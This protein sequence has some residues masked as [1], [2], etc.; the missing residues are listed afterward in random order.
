MT[1][2]AHDYR[3]ALVRYCRALR[4]PGELRVIELVWHWHEMASAKRRLEALAEEMAE[5]ED[6]QMGERVTERPGA[7]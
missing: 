6:E 4:R 2:P 3:D 1:D 7:I 5:M